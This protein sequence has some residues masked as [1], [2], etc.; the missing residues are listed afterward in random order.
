VRREAAA[1]P[2]PARSLSTLAGRGRRTCEGE[3]TIEEVVA[4]IKKLPKHKR[5]AKAQ[6][7]RVKAQLRAPQRAGP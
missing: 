5:Q 3:I 7:R 6:G 2:P 1:P 4:T